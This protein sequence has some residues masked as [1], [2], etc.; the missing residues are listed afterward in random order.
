[1]LGFLGQM[2]RVGLG[3]GRVWSPIRTSNLALLLPRFV[4]AC[5][6]FCLSYIPLFL[7]PRFKTLSKLIVA[8]LSLLPLLHRVHFIEIF[9]SKS[10]F[11]GLR[12]DCLWKEH[13]LHRLQVL[14]SQKLV[15]FFHNDQE[16][17]SAGVTLHCSSVHQH[18][19]P[20]IFTGNPSRI[21]ITWLVLKILGSGMSR[22]RCLLRTVSIILVNLDVT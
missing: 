21:L 7:K 11:D 2:A 3:F 15:L 19:H 1:M 13:L 10:L 14:L 20:I 12:L 5:S 4:H 18:L 6:H 9:A 8:V 17:G 16:V 22:A